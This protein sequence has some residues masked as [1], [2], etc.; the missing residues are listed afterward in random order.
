VDGSRVAPIPV[1]QVGVAPEIAKQD[2]RAQQQSTVNGVRRAY[3]AVLQAESWLADAREQVSSWRE[4]VAVVTKQSS[5]HVVQ[6]P[7]MLQAKAGLAQ[8]EY[9]VT[10]DAHNLETR[11]EQLNYQLGRDP[12]TPFRVSTGG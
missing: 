6:P 10:V 4:V 8:A 9:A 2:L 11:K 3:Y 7:V 5:V 12:S 1:R